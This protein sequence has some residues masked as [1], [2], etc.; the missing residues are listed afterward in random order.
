MAT[1]TIKLSS[2]AHSR[3]RSARKS[4]S[5]SG[6]VQISASLDTSGNVETITRTKNGE[7]TT[8]VRDRRTGKRKVITGK[9]SFEQQRQIQKELAPKTTGIKVKPRVERV[10]KQS[11][12]KQLLSPEEFKKFQQR[13]QTTFSQTPEQPAH[14]PD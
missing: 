4:K 2:S 6:R 10:R 14:H 1:R 3:A 13:K 5:N 11:L 12:V 9:P 7:T 8:T